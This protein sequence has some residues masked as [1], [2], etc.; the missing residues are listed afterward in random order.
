MEKA[1]VKLDNNIVKMVLSMYMGKGWG[2]GTRFITF[3]G[4]KSN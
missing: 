4:R 3:F 2:K 1:K